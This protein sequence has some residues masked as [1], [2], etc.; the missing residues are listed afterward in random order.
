MSICFA[1]EYCATSRKAVNSCQLI[2]FAVSSATWLP[3]IGIVRRD[4]WPQIRM[5]EIFLTDFSIIR[6][7]CV[8]DDTDAELSK[9][10]GT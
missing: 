6:S 5:G 8:Q 9:R 1:R 3:K 4:C 2:N 10:R 7:V